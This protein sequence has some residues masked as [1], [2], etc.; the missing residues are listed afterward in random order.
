M[1]TTRLMALE[2]D[3]LTQ[4]LPDLQRQLAKHSL[5]E[6]EARDCGQL[7]QRGGTEVGL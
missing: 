1:S 4:Y 2:R 6:L 5:L 7:Y 3:T